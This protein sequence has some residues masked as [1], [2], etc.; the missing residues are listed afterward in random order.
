MNLKKKIGPLP[1]WSWLVI[2]TGIALAAVLYKKHEAASSSSSSS[3]T[4]PNAVD[5]SNPLGLTYAEEQQ[6]IAEG[7]DPNTGVSYA[8]EQAANS[9]SAGTGDTGTS[10][11]GTTADTT[12]GATLA[13]EIGDVGTALQ[14]LEGLQAEP[15]LQTVV[16][17]A[18]PGA[19]TITTHKGGPFYEWYVKATGKA[20]P[21]TLSSKNYLYQAWQQ[22][23]LPGQIKAMFTG[24]GNAGHAAKKKKT[25]KTTTHKQT[26][27]TAGK[28]P[29]KGATKVKVATP[30]KHT[31]KPAKP[32]RP[33]GDRR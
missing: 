31:T 33:R 17:K 16:T 2:A 8:S 9:Q 11:T 6:D 12:P 7:I 24:S 30:K 1:L 4:N 3:T 10:D 29:T 15:A 20:P 25:T 27:S 13:G 32:K 26:T 5:P 14:A 23:V 21:K 18:A 19:K 28:H 22:H